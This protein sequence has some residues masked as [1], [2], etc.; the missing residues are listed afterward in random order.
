MTARLPAARLFDGEAA[1]HYTLPTDLLDLKQAFARLAQAPPP[2]HVSEVEQTQR[3]VADTL[4]AAKA[5]EVLPG[6]E[7]VLAARRAAESAGVLARARDVAL[8]R[9]AGEVSTTVFDLGDVLITEHLR[10]ALHAVLH[11]LRG[12]LELTEPYGDSAAA[13]LR[14]PDKVRKAWLGIDAHVTRYEIIRA[15]RDALAQVG[16]R[17]DH[18]NDNEF[19]RVRNLNDFWPRHKRY[20][21]AAGAGAPWPTQAR[22][23]VVWFI[24]HGAQLWLPTAAE[25]DERYNEVYA[26]GLARM[27]RQRH[28]TA[29]VTA[30]GAGR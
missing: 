13:M 29:A 15:G 14:A 28:A 7:Q 30:W 23:Q 20:G 8:E 26:E 22:Q 16:Y 9:L 11:E 4:T 1:G 2:V 21:M 24:Q 10:P 6:A 27:E 25:Q 19:L 5:N 17:P 18:D 12:T 3:L